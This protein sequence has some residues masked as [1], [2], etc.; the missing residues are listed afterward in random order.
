MNN[1]NTFVEKIV[2]YIETHIN[3][4]L[5]VSSILNNRGYA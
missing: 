4:D 5:S 2:D 1:N 3:E